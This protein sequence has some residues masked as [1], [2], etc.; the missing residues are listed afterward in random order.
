MED[1]IR[2]SCPVCGSVL[3][4][5]NSSDNAFK[6]V[7]CPVCKKRSPY[8]SFRIVLTDANEDHT[9]YPTAY[10]DTGNI[11]GSLVSQ[12]LS[13]RWQL[14]E[15]R[16]VVGRE[17]QSSHAQIRLPCTDR[18]MSRE[19]LVIEVSRVEGKGFVHC[20]SLTK[21]QVNPTYV[22]SVL[23][24]YGDKIVLHHNDVIKL[25][26]IELRFEQAGGESTE[27]L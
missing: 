23:L 16:N 25:P 19:H 6:E 1:I 18:R 22:G 20:A 27:L 2:I 21:E 11:I 3:V 13:S 5:K 8:A 24:E 9:E 12:A 14:H 17:A 15:G 10:C 26:G 7:T 4:V